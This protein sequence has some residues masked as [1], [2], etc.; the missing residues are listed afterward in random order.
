MKSTSPVEY[1]ITKQAFH[2]NLQQN[3]YIHTSMTCPQ[4]AH[5]I[6]ELFII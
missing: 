4:C 5:N 2:I 1:S 6:K 3:N